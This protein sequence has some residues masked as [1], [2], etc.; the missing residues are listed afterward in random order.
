MNGVDAFVGF[1]KKLAVGAT[2]AEFAFVPPKVSPMDEAGLS[3]FVVAPKPPK[4][5]ADE[6]EVAPVVPFAVPN[7]PFIAGAVL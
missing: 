6:V 5:G 2:G 1:L 4:L 3:L 7:R